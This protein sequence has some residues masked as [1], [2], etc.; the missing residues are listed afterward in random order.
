V[1]VIHPDSR[2][3]GFSVTIKSLGRIQRRAVA[4]AV[5][6]AGVAATVLLS[7]GVAAAWSPMYTAWTGASQC[8]A[9]LYV[10]P[11]TSVG[12][13]SSHDYAQANAYQSS[14]DGA[15]SDCV[16]WLERSTDGGSTWSPISGN[17]W[18]SGP[19][20]SSSFTSWYYDGPG[21]MSRA[22]VE[23]ETTFVHACTTGY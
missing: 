14:G 6:G 19:G 18:T 1:G 4:I 7:A 13:A 5:T 21:Y 20:T 22:C 15:S 3:K 8:M 23:D 17:H 11:G 9:S 16:G 2:R 12:Q 10:E